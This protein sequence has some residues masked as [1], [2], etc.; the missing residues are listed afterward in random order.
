VHWADGGAT[1]L[2]STAKP[3]DAQYVL[4][5]TEGV[6]GFFG[7]SSIERLPT[8]VAIRAKLG[9]GQPA[10]RS[11]TGSRGR[12]SACLAARNVA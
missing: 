2:D 12:A 8:E 9:V 7:A 1:S 5:H 6:V 4:D 3:A 11:S 10:R